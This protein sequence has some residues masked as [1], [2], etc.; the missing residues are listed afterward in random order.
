M[1]HRAGRESTA[2]NENMPMSFCIDPRTRNCN[3]PCNGCKMR[4]NC[5]RSKAV[6]KPRLGDDTLNVRFAPEAAIALVAV[7]IIMQG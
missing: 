1:V 5:C 3:P 6:S 7:K 4:I 2:P